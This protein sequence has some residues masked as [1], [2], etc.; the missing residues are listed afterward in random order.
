MGNGHNGDHL[1]RLQRQRQA[2]IKAQEEIHQAEGK[3]DSGGVQPADGNIAHNQGKQNAPASEGARQFV[4]GKI[5]RSNP[6]R[7]H[8]R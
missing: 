8:P 2:V 4:K 7:F 3:E 6:Q 5:M 1:H